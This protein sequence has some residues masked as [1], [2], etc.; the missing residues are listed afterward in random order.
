[1]AFCMKSKGIVKLA[2]QAFKAKLFFDKTGFLKQH[3]KEIIE[4][5]KHGGY[6]LVLA[7]DDT[8]PIGV[9]LVVPRPPK[10]FLELTNEVHVYVEP[11]HRKQGIAR[12]LFKNLEDKYRIP[13]C[14][15]HTRI[16][17]SKTVNFFKKF[18]VFIVPSFFTLS[19]SDAERF[20]SLSSMSDKEK[21]QIGV[22]TLLRGLTIPES[23]HVI[24]QINLRIKRCSRKKKEIA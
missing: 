7:F 20:I 11:S 2:E 22:S 1:M 4:T 14:Y 8:R 9:L 15:L 6:K 3:L 21:Y 19:V 16:S 5:K 23:K 17:D 18:G 12:K 24:K 10:S 13:S